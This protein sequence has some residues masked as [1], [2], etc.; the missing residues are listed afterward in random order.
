MFAEF[1]QN[2]F[3]GKC[4]RSILVQLGMATLILFGLWTAWGFCASQLAVSA[5]FKI[6]PEQILIAE[7][8]EWIPASFVQEVLSDYPDLKETE[9][10]LL[11]S[12]LPATLAKAF[13]LHPWVEYVESVEMTWPAS[14][15]IHIAFRTPVAVVAAPL[16]HYP[17][18]KGGGFLIDA[19]GNLLPDAY[20]QEHSEKLFDYIWI[21]GITSVPMGSYGEPWNDVLVSEAAAL[22]ELLHWSNATLGLKKIVVTPKEEQGI[23]GD[24]QL[25]TRRGTKIVWGEFPVAASLAARNLPHSPERSAKIRRQVIDQQEPKVTYLRYL[26]GCYGSL[27]RVPDDQKP[28]DLTKKSTE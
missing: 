7:P 14:I 21:H 8:P 4:Q 27:D 22:A 11:D 26:V 15:V 3:G 13:E 10:T 2:L 24:Y 12:T 1:V 17:D 28:I 16:E 19:A 5:R 9:L 25:E 18:A 23:G 6:L 20:F